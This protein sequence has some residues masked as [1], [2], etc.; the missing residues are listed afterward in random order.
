MAPC[1]ENRSPPSSRRLLSARARLAQRASQP[2][3]S[4]LTILAQRIHLSYTE[5]VPDEIYVFTERTY[6]RLAEATV[7]P[8]SVTDVLYGP[9]RVRRHIGASLQVAG[10][11]RSGTWLAV[12]MIEVRTTNTP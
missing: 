5:G 10:R 1:R 11:D 8:L 3:S 7:N 4:L 2:R 6:E 9:Q 12:T